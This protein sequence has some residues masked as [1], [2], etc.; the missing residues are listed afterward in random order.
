MRMNFP[1]AVLIL[2]VLSAP[3]YDAAFASQEKEAASK[4]ERNPTDLA[5]VPQPDFATADASVQQQIRDAQKALG[6]TLARSGSSSVQRGES[7]GALGQVY[8]AYGFD[9]AARVSY[10]NAAKLDAQSFRWHY[11][12]GY[13]EQRI[14]DNDSAVRSYQRAQAIRP[15][16]PYVLLRLG[17]VELSANHTDLAKSWFLKSMAQPGPA[18]AALM[19]LGKTALVEHDYSSALKYFK[20]ALA[21]EPQASSLHYQLAM[22][23]R[24]LGDADQ[25]QKELQARGDAEP[26]VK[27]PLLDQINLL[28]QGKTGLLERASKAMHEG[29]FSD[30]CAAY[31]EMIR[32]DPNDAIAHRYLGI[33]LAKSGNL[34]EAIQEYERAMRLDPNS[35][36]THY[37]MGILLIH[38]GKE[39]A[40]I[41]H[42]RE[43]SKLDP[44]LVATHFQLANLLMRQ[45]RDEDASREYAIVA[46]L[47]PKNRFA[48]LM[49]AMALI[50][51]GSYARGRKVLEEASAAFP[52][53]PDIANA[54]ARL[55]VAAP[56]PT[57]REESRGL[58]IVQS[59][60]ENQ[61]GDAFEE[62]VTLAM[63]L[64][65]VG[66]FKEAAY[67]Q[68][69][70]IQQL[71]SLGKVTL[72]RQLRPNLDL[73]AR[74]KRCT[75]PWAPDDPI[76][77]PVPGKL[78]L[79]AGD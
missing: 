67:Y 1:G 14:G 5:E 61:Q 29:R 9:D 62:G 13:L 65:A 56:D 28:K 64:A 58:R 72:A 57:V 66:R 78:E 74:E 48:R 19:G 43:A 24:G 59:L 4:T 63:A 45:G 79:S 26:T 44:G 18:A 35:A 76:F 6:D 54:L 69:A 27:D 46:E 75:K 70:I 38:T 36:P 40:A 15:K 8:Q 10:E 20:Q 25:M 30:A 33:A 39:E 23:Y 11:Y 37:S 68:Q 41:E 77:H 3:S 32:L 22:A 52:D 34:T 16:D 17:N 42:F 49:Q 51:A 12:A 73:Y 31:R 71:E 2:L 55:L 7:Y 21:R 47:D 60:I 50:H 53:D